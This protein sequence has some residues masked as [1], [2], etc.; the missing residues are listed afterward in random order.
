VTGLLLIALTTLGLWWLFNM[1]RN[2]PIG[3]VRL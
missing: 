1:M 3:A 2:D